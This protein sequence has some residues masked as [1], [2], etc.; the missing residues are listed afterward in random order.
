MA[1]VFVEVATE[2]EVSVEAAEP[3]EAGACSPIRAG[4]EIASAIPK[5]WLAAS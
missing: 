4:N 1:V 5:P 3:S 2:I